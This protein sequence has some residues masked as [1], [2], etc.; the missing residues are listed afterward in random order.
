MQR[1]HSKL[2]MV[3][4]CARCLRV[5][6]E[7]QRWLTWLDLQINGYLGTLDLT[8]NAVDIDGINALADAL[9]PNSSLECLRLRWG[10]RIHQC[11]VDLS[12]WH[13]APALACCH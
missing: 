5:T 13:T 4:T 9:K 10:T 1:S 3:L 8:S 12:P 7:M 11:H 2:Q 6:V